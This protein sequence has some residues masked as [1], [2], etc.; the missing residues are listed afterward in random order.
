MP[1]LVLSIP[2]LGKPAKAT[3]LRYFWGAHQRFFHNLCIS[4]KVPTA[5]QLAKEAIAEGKLSV[6]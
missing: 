6:G 2:L 5:V 1:L 3:V 4:L